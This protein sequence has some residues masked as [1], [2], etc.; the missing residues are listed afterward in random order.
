MNNGQ[1]AREFTAAR[2][3]VHVPGL[4]EAVFRAGKALLGQQHRDGHWVF[5]LEADTTIPSEY[6]LL[7]HYLG[8]IE[9][10]LQ[11]RIARYIRAAQGADGGWPLF[12]GGAIDISCSVKA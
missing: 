8:R 10:E 6:I 5:E 7:Q 2:G 11:A 12:Y 1:T 9:P 3:G 4:D